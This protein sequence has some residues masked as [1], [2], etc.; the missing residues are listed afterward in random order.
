METLDS[1][2]ASLPPQLPSAGTQLPGRLA[3]ID[4]D[5]AAS[6]TPF[7]LARFEFESGKGNEGTKILMV[8]WDL[9]LSP[10]FSLTTSKISAPPSKAWEVSWNG[11]ANYLP[12][13]DDFEGTHK[14][15]YFLLPPG[16]F[17]PPI[18]NITR[19][20]GTTIAINPLPAIFP[21]A[22]GAS[23]LDAGTRGVLH[24][25][26]A[27]KRLS[28]LQEEID[29]EMTT[30]PES[31]GL[32]MVLQEQQWIVTYFG[33]TPKKAAVG[34]R[35]MSAS[36]ALP[37]PISPQPLVGGR[38]GKKLEGLKLAT[39]AADLIAGSAGE[40]PVGGFPTSRLITTD[41]RLI[42]KNAHPRPKSFS[43]ASSDM[44]LRSFSSSA[45]ETTTENSSL[46]GSASL[47][48][49]LGGSSLHPRQQDQD[50]EE[51]LFALPMSP[52]NPE[53]KRSPFSLV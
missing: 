36:Q 51:E 45:R 33:I 39:S 38:L 2:R 13:S 34:G 30:N 47:D 41:L 4:P 6:P 40:T 21:P 10:T 8:E 50:Q 20:D 49:M 18:V 32:E 5:S 46:G 44:V 12:S 7:A 24:T 25:I 37:S 15:V 27:K 35:T 53:M 42:D 22:L 14:R 3:G 19:H 29:A 16:A 23:E 48:A 11:K 31:V 28:E 9:S 26:W 17:V 52:R 1:T 43:P